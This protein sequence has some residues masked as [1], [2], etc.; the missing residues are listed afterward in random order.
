IEDLRR[1]LER[2]LAG[3]IGD[4]CEA[5]RGPVLDGDLREPHPLPAAN[6]E[7][8]VDGDRDHRH[9]GAEGDPA[10]AR[11][12]VP[13]AAAA[14]AAALRVH[15]HAAPALQDRVNGLE[16]LLILVPAADWERATVAQDPTD[17]RIREQL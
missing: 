16:R 14:R 17:H 4:L 12:G 10:E 6:T 11:L 5:H 2:L 9:A 3:R 13:E 7:R 8:A 15:E 1:D